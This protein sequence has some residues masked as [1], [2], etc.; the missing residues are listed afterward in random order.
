M[1][2]F[3]NAQTIHMEGT[4]LLLTETK[5]IH[6]EGTLLLLTE[7]KTTQKLPIRETIS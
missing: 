7:T 6:M 1:R 4:L 5:T 3:R 2:N